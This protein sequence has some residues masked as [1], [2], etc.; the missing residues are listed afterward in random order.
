MKYAV[1]DISSSSLSLLVA[2]KTSTDGQFTVLK[3]VRENLSVLQYADEGVLSERGVE[4]IVEN[5]Q[6]LKEICK[7]EGVQ[8][9]YVISTASIRNFKN[10]KWVSA[11]IKRRAAVSVNLLKGEEEALCDYAANEEYAEQGKAVLIDLGGGSIELCSL[12]EGKATSLQCYEF[13]PIQLNKKFVEDIHPTKDEAKEIKKYVEKKLVK[14]NEEC[15]SFASAVLVGA[16]SQ[17]I[18]SVYKNYYKEESEKKV[19]DYKKLK[20]LKKH[21]VN[22]SE[23]SML[24]LKYAPEKI[25]TLVTATVVLCAILKHYGAEKAT[26]SSYGVKEGF[27]QLILT[28]QRK[29]ARTSDLTEVPEAVADALKLPEKKKKKKEGQDGKRE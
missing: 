16:T 19:L 3:R 27:L 18:Y 12:E 8:K 13:G 6:K 15:V 20:K 22:S 2:Q 14:A 28:G 21:L 5:L 24:I 9:C 26:I 10:F 23:R 11:E 17:A 1:I 7:K 4:K 29:Y 25:Y